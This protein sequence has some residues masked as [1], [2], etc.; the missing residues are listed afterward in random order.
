MITKFKLENNE[1]TY[2]RIW[3]K[4]HFGKEF[5]QYNY[6]KDN[7]INNTENSFKLNVYQLDPNTRLFYLNNYLYKVTSEEPFYNYLDTGRVLSIKENRHYSNV[8]SKNIFYIYNEIIITNKE[9]TNFEEYKDKEKLGLKLLSDTDTETFYLV[10]AEDLAKIK[11]RLAEIEAEEKQIKEEEQEE[12]LKEV[13]EQEKVFSLIK[14][15]TKLSLIEDNDIIIKDNYFIDKSEGLKIEFKDKVVNLFSK[16][17]LITENSRYIDNN[18]FITISYRT[19]FDKLARAYRLGKWEEPLE[20]KLSELNKKLLNFKI[21]SYDPET[22]AEVLLKEIKIDNNKND[23]GKDRFKINGIKI[24]KQKLEK[25]FEFINTGRYGVG[26]ETIIE[27]LTNFENYLTKIR[28]YSGTQLELLSGKTVE[29]HL[30]H[31]TVPIHFNIKA[32]DREHWIISIDDFSVERTYTSVKET[33]RYLSGGGLTAISSIC[34]RLQAGQK[35]EDILISKVSGYIE[36]RRLAEE[37][38]FNLFTEF[39][40][41]YK[42]KVFKKDGGYIVKGKLKNYIIKMKDENNVGVWSYPANEYVCIN[43]KTKAGQ[44]LCKYDKLLQFCLVMLNDG[45]L[46]EEIHTIH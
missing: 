3:Q 21:Y 38:A 17:D 35:L 41:R 16:E 12:E 18:N 2:I 15:Y 39:L 33:F 42:T 34:D 7:E 29:I 13:K 43:E 5:L 27:R 40:A 31:V 19:F 8:N 37:R 9:I 10:F 24:P 28:L 46:R 6:F 23:K 30:N 22:K 36:K 25:V 26:K 11:T 1:E 45:N 14:Q 44:Y 20:Q 32:E 4:I